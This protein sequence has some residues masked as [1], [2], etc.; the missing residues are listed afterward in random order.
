METELLREYLVIADEMNFTHAAKRL[1]TTQ[2]TLSK[3]VAALEREFGETLFRRARRGIE[4]TEAGSVLYRR[5]AAIVDLMDGTRAEIASLRRNMTVRVAGLLQ[6]GDVM[7]LLS[8]VARALRTDEQAS[9]SLLPASVPSATSLVLGSEADV[10]ICHKNFDGAEIEGLVCVELYREKLLAFVESTNEL[11]SC[12]G[13]SIDD[14]RTASLARLSGSYADYGWT[15]IRRIC[16]GHGFDPRGVP[17]P[18]DNMIDLMTYPLGDAVLLLQRGMMPVDTFTNEHRCCLPVKDDDAVFVV[19]AYCRADDE[20]RL[21]P[22]L[23]VLRR[24]AAHMGIEGDGPRDGSRGRFRSRCDALAREVD[25]NESEEAAMQGFA[26]GRS[27]DRIAG[28]LGLSRIMVG[29]LLASVYKK[30]GVRD[31]QGLL[32][33]IEAKELPW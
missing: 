21:R 10:A 8:R 20:E 26:R 28:D 27:I 4:L 33:R 19:C 17:L 31:R 29:D 32:D 5:A 16:A 7:G 15:N 1:H 14:L 9:L 3:H 25:L 23:D 2:S 11:A 12:K 13:L 6:N 24:E 22:V 30:A 18:I